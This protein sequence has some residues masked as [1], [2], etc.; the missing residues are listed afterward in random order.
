MTNKRKRIIIASATILGIIGVIILL[1]FTLFALRHVEV[2]F[3]TSTLNLSATS[4]EI[5][6]AG[7]FSYGGSVIF[8]SKKNYKKKLEKTFPYLKV[9]NIETVFPDKFVIHVAERQEVYAIE[10]DENEVYICDEEFKVLKIEENFTSNSSNAIFLSG[11][12]ASQA[13]VGDFLK[14]EGYSDIYSAFLENNRLLF[15]QIAIIKEIKFEK[16]FNEK[17]N[18]SEIWAN[19]TLFSGQTVRLGNANMGLSKKVSAFLREFS[20]LYTRIGEDIKIV[21]EDGQSEVVGVW[22][23]EKLDHAIIEINNYYTK[24]GIYLKIL[25]NA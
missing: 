23:K 25:P 7:E 8:H 22:T 5:V 11:V 18:G 13:E 24:D 15:E 12:L 2:D 6:E 1:L 4:E 21:S 14:V 9:V 17:I 3:R 20:L 19:L 10:K 16:I